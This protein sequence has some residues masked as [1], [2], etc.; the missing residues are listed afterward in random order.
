MSQA[1]GNKITP[2]LQ[3]HIVSQDETTRNG[4][5]FSSDFILKTKE[6]EV[7]NCVRLDFTSVFF[8]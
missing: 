1:H 2:A 6:K 5:H 4:T 3:Y 8:C 7:W